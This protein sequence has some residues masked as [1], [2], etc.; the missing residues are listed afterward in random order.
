MLGIFDEE[1][2]TEQINGRLTADR[3]NQL[4]GPR[5]DM[6]SELRLNTGALRVDST[7]VA[8]STQPM[9]RK[10]DADSPISQPPNEPRP[11]PALQA[12]TSGSAKLHQIADQF[13]QSFSEAIGR[14]VSEIQRLMDKER[15]ESRAAFNLCSIA[16]RET[17]AL[18]AQVANLSERLDSLADAQ[19]EASLRLEKSEGRLG[20]EL[21]HSLQELRG[22][23]GKRLDAQ[24]D[25]IRM[26][27]GSLNDKDERLERVFAAFQAMKDTSSTGPVLRNPLEN[28]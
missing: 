22:S 28:L 6:T 8:P 27:H 1:K 18:K 26:L 24:A 12:D 25:A 14:A 21:S 15:E 2:N 5:K 4:L 9:L 20:V 7:P 13:S 10:S 23:L 11:S 3:L 17:A 16:S 19:Q